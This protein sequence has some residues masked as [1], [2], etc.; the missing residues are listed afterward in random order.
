MD[1]RLII[2]KQLCF[3]ERRMANFIPTNDKDMLPLSIIGRSYRES[4]LCEFRDGRR[5]DRQYKDVRI[6][7]N[8]L[9]NLNWK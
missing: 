8:I 7:R 2:A 9:L 4:S 6:L 3:V 5:C 1:D